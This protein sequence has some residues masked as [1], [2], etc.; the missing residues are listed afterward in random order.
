MN[1]FNYI[2][3]LY[4]SL[5]DEIAEK[6]FNP[7]KVFIGGWCPRQAEGLTKDGNHF[8]FRARG[9]QWY[10][11]ISKKENESDFE[12]DFDKEI[13]HYGNRDYKKWPDCGWLPKRECIKLANKAFKKYYE[14]N[15]V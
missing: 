3:N 4:N 9:T 7:N 2:H 8:Y 15:E 6:Y 11:K 14:S 10:L 12:F 1:I 13:F 5:L